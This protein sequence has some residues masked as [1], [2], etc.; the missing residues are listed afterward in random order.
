LC[1]SSSSSYVPQHVQRIDSLLREGLPGPPLTVD[2]LT[3]AKHEL[4]FLAEIDA[5]EDGR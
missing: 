1:A 2:L 3:A 4:D 5:A